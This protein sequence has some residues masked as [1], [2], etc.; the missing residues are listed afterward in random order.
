MQSGK[1]RFS[2][3]SLMVLLKHIDNEYAQ[4]KYYEI[5]S[6]YYFSNYKIFRKH[7]PYIKKYFRNSGILLLERFKIVIKPTYLL[8][9]LIKK[10]TM[11]NAK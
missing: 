7:L 10:K 2:G 8:F 5:V 11:M 4:K 1:I 9:S 6:S 3:D